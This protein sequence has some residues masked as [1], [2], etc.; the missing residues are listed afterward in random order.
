MQRGCRMSEVCWDSFE[1]L[2]VNHKRFYLAIREFD[3]LKPYWKLRED[4]VLLDEISEAI[5]RWSSGQRHIAQ[6]FVNIWLGFSHFDFD[7]M[8]AINCLGGK[9]REA[10]VNWINDPFFP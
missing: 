7:L 10:L 3:F 4:R 2:P 1:A 5:N 9:Y 6:F 8:E